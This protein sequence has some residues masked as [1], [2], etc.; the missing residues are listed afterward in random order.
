MP[1]EV[2][3]G[4][5]LAFCVH[6]LSAWYRL[7]TSGRVLLVAAYVSASYAIV[8]TALFLV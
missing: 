5:A 2:I 6:P 7:P 1:L 8:L 3:T 4:R